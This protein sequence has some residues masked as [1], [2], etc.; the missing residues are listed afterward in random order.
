MSS[1]FKRTFPPKAKQVVLLCKEPS[2][3]V[4]YTISL[5]AKQLVLVSEIPE[6]PVNKGISEHVKSR[7]GE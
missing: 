1:V 3:Q 4:F 5:T 2:L 6:T 7:D